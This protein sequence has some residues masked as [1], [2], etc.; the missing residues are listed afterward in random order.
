M[1]RYHFL[2]VANFLAA[3]GG[4]IILIA[5]VIAPKGAIFKDTILAFL[6]GSVIGV[7]LERVVPRGWARPLAPWFSLS[8]AATSVILFWFIPRTDAG[9]RLGSAAELLFIVLLSIRFSLSFFARSV[10]AESA[11]SAKSEENGIALAELGYYAGMALAIMGWSRL[12]LSMWEALLADALLQCITGLIDLFTLGSLRRRTAAAE[13][14]TG[15]VSGPPAAVPAPVA[16]PGAPPSFDRGWYWRMSSAVVCLTVGFQAVLLGLSAWDDKGW[17]PYLLGWFYVGLALAALTC[18]LLKLKFDWG[19]GN[20]AIS[21]E[22]VWA[23]RNLSYG[24]V[25]LAAVAIMTAAVLGIG[26]SG[27]VTRATLA[28]VAVAAFIYQLPVLTLLG[29]IAEAASRSELERMVMRTYLLVLLCTIF[30]FWALKS[31]PKNYAG[32]ALLTL[33]CA[34]IAFL[35]VRRRDDNYA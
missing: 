22:R 16:A 6:A 30:G 33:A 25:M 7:M 32:G 15:Q 31:F 2:A 18:R 9:V 10:R 23:E 11:K 24:L 17:S 20:A 19:A 12:G 5:G 21:S 28:L 13:N 8:V 1:K 3:G 29:R 14:D 27:S 4:G 26:L 35:A 34:M